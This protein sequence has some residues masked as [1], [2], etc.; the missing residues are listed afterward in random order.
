MMKVIARLLR[1]VTL[2]TVG[3]GLQAQAQPTDFSLPPLPN[4]ATSNPNGLTGSM[5][6]LPNSPIAP[7]AGAQ[8]TTATPSE[9]AD[10][11]APVAIPELANLP[12][13][14]DPNAPTTTA[15]ETTPTTTAGVTPAPLPPVA[16]EGTDMVAGE[17]T[18]DA[19]ASAAPPINVSAPPMSLP[20]L[21][22][23]T[24]PP[25]GSTQTASTQSPMT[26]S[27]PEVS[28]DAPAAP[29][30]RTWKT[31][32]APAVIP[33]KTNFNYRRQILPDA[34]YRKQYDRE[35]AHLP[36]QVTREDYAQLLI[37]RVAAN[38]I[39][40][41]RALLNEGLSVNTTDG[42]GQSLLG[43]ARSSGARDTERL[44]IARG[45]S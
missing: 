10:Q 13:P 9:V 11:P 25:S 29:R 39:N 43:V 1:L 18:P 14:V 27:L 8:K 26:T 12:T 30:A 24:A 45:A 4:M 15:T 35:N 2:I 32:L 28:V 16:S 3:W 41:T 20:G 21:S 5:P 42:S 31:T 36:L 19:P 40:G 37:Q 34:I 44:L 22:F 7:N 17:S 33:P 23:P 6:P 38:D